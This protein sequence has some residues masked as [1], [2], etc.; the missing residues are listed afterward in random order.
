LKG[1]C[2]IHRPLVAAAIEAANG[3]FTGNI[4]PDVTGL[5]NI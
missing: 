2:V 4:Y 1:K 3:K 5:G